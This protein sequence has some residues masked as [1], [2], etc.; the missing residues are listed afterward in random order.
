MSKCALTNEH[1]YKRVGYEDESRDN[2]RTGRLRTVAYENLSSQVG[3]YFIKR[4]SNSIRNA[5]A[6]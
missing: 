4:Q 1:C 6:L 5:P 2:Y 3:V